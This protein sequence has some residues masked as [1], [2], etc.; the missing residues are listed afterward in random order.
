[1]PEERLSLFPPQ[2][3]KSLQA[4]DPGL[5]CQAAAQQRHRDPWDVRDP[6]SCCLSATAP[7]C[8]EAHATQ[9]APS[10]GQPPTPPRNIPPPRGPVLRGKK[11]S[12]KGPPTSHPSKGKGKRRTESLPRKSRRRISSLSIEAP[13]CALHP[14]SR[15]GVL[16]Y[17]VRSVPTAT[18]TELLQSLPAV[19][20]QG[21]RAPRVPFE[22]SCA[23]ALSPNPGSQC[24]RPRTLA[25]LARAP[26]P[27]SW[28]S[29]RAAA[30]HAPQTPY[31]RARNP[32]PVRP[33]PG[34]SGP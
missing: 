31:P 33:Q 3:L 10:L 8:Q 32:L 19:S 28:D 29:C 2:T 15:D 13:S 23:P 30:R 14:E 9:L 18:A 7:A 34:P 20:V 6:P 21:A 25:E 16:G 1:M 22:W 26:Q 12:A 5:T 27:L 4:K 17:K 24:P 11:G